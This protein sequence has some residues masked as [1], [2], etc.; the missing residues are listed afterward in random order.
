MRS[1][2]TLCDEGVNL[3]TNHARRSVGLHK[4]PI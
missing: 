4:L 1:K 3:L 2:K